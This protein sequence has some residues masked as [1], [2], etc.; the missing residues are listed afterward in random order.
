MIPRTLQNIGKAISNLNPEDVR[1]IAG[2]SVVIGLTAPSGE[3]LAAMEE[4]LA[5]HSI[6]QK[7]RVEALRCIYR[8]SSAEAPKE[9]DVELHEAGAAHYEGSFPFR[10]DEPDLTVKE[11]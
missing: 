7:K 1:G 4:Y 6:S 10:F 5:P 8:T 9:F 2:R 3:A 11:V